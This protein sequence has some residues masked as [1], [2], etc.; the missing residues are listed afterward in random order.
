MLLAVGACIR[1]S[2]LETP[3]FASTRRDAGVLRVT[4]VEVWRRHKRTMLLAMST[5]W[6]EG[7][8]FNDPQTVARAG[9]PA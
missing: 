3:A 2:V 5:R 6:V 1:L 8:T 9:P 7:F 4:V